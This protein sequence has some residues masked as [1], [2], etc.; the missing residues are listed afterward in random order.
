[1]QP[2]ESARTTTSR[3]TSDGVVAVVVAG[4]DLARAAGRWRRR[5]RVTWSA[6]VLAPALPGRSSPES[7]SPVASAKQNIGWKPN[8][9]L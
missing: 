7:A 2:A 1:M 8:P 5:G 9:P 6:T 3:L 4:R